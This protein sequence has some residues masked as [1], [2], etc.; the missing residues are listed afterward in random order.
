MTQFR[1]DETPQPKPFSRILGLKRWLA[2]AVLVAEQLLPRILLPGSIALLFLAFAWLGFFRVAPF[3]L[4][5]A[6]L[7]AF[8]VGFLAALVPVTRI[9]LPASA[10]ADRM[11]EERNALPHQA[12]RVQDD[13]PATDDPLGEALWREHQ[14]RMARLIGA[15]DTGLPRPDIAR[16]DPFALRTV[17]VLLACLAFAYS[18][19]NRAGLLSDALRLPQA[20]VETANI[21]ID[22]WVTPPPYTGRAPIFLTGKPGATPTAEDTG[23]ITIPQFSDLTVRITG[24]GPDE[25]V[26]YAETGAAEP[27]AIP[28]AGETAKEAQPQS[29]AAGNAAQDTVRS[30]NAVRNHVY[31][32]VKDGELVVG[33]QR[34]AFKITPDG[35]PQIAFD[36]IPRPTVNA[37]LEIAFVATDDYGVAQAWAEIKPLDQAAEG[38]RPLYPLPEYRLDLPRRNAREAKGTTSRN[39]SEH[40]L[41]GKRVQVTLV[42]RDAAGQEG[43]SPP[44]DMILPARQFLQP[45]A[46]AVA[47]QRQVF[48][49]NA[50]DLPRAIDLNDAVA[51]LAE[52]W[53][54]NLTH[55]LLLKSARTR[56]ALAYNDD[57]LRD[58]AGY[59]WEIALGIEDGDLSLAERRLREAQQALSDALERNASDQEIAKLMQE[60][61]QAMQEYM[62]ALAQQAMKNPRMTGKL[63]PNNI[64]RQQDLE[65]MMD[66]IENLARSG[67]RDQARQM[68]SELQR[69]MNNL[70]AGRGQQ[71]MGEQNDAMRQQIDKLGKLL[72]QQQ[73][74]MDETFKLDQALRDRMQRG[75]PLQGEDNELFGQEMPQEPGQR[76]DPNAQPDP[77]DGMTAEQLKDALKQLK[78]Q[79]DALGK[80]LGELN[81]SLESMGIKPGKGFGDAKREMEGASGALGKG[82]GEQ[83]VGNQGRALQALREGAQDMMNQMQ[84]QGQG[85]GMGIPQYGQNGRDPLGRRQQNSGPDFGDQVKV[86]D[87]IDSQRA[88]QILEEIRRRLGDSLSPEAER[89]YLERLLDMR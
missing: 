13:R 83:A 28:A 74:L 66:Q 42:A 56:M 10:D 68:L 36:G 73:Q 30:P 6:V 29:K 22:A 40:P 50:N 82:Q 58:A 17:P 77:L 5:A 37:A 53:I 61:R 88:R 84:G 86:P 57:M 24:A 62:Q 21:R 39:L 67:A 81:Q 78:E 76:S 89:Q 47:E 44:Q 52:E 26:H 45:L 18:Y 85:P 41:A 72:Q 12:I 80:Q 43:R 69:M 49:L 38:A 59:L 54:P 48:A 65:K 3:W 1:Q 32:V 71:Q 14:A 64:M 55:F 70:Q 7:F 27:I 20:S 33:G 75:D 79:Q 9:R 15:L 31:K 60:L 25:I 87:E 4:H 19:S 11:L 35:V 23:T 46:G 16:H 8:A 34:W 63:D 51:S 2:R